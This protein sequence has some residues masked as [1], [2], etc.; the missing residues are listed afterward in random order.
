MKFFQNVVF[1]NA[2]TASMPLSFARLY[3]PAI[4]KKLAERRLLLRSVCIN[5]SKFDGARGLS[6]EVF[7]EPSSCY[8]SNCIY[9]SKPCSS[10]QAGNR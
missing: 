3:E 6:H 1:A 5:A 7:A 10:L 2:Q 9:A 8:Y 4:A